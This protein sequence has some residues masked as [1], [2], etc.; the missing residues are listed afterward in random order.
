MKLIEEL[1]NF[2]PETETNKMQIKIKNEVTAWV[3]RNKIERQGFPVEITKESNH[4]I[5]T[6]WSIDLIDAYLLA[7]DEGCAV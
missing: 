6:V 1:K 7:N 3:L 2:E 4:F 5:L